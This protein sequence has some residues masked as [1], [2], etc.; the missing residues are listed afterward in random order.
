MTSAAEP[1][2]QIFGITFHIDRVAFTIPIGDGYN[3]YWYAIIIAAG[4]LLAMAY[5]FRRAPQFGIDKDRMLDVVLVSF[6]AALVGARAYYLIFDGKPITSV[7]DIFAVRNGGLAIYGGIIGAFLAGFIMCRVRKVNVLAMFDLAALGF[8][9]GQGIGR[10]G[11]FINQE[12]YGAHTDSIF[13]MTGSI[14]G[15][16]PVH[17]CFLYESFF[18]LLGFLLLHLVSKKRKF[19]GQIITLYMIW[20]GV[21]RF[22][23]EGLRTDSLKIGIL[24]ISQIVSFI[25][26]VAGVIFYFVLLARAKRLKAETG[27]YSGLFGDYDGGED[28]ATDSAEVKEPDGGESDESDETAEENGVDNIDNNTESEDEENGDDN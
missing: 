21:V 18:C 28:E 22:F 15:D 8:L 16:D 4:L 24:R 27:D 19:D 10:W 12:A 11:N 14:I 2:I 20:Y 5:A 23:I 25:A 1:Y 3:I 7:G 17:P 6:I 9:I 26:V 13:G